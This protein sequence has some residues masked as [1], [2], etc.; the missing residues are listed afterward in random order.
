MQNI[1]SC[2]QYDQVQVTNIQPPLTPSWQLIG[3]HTGHSKGCAD[4]RCRTAALEPQECD[5]RIRLPSS[6]GL[7]SRSYLLGG[8][9]ESAC[10]AACN[11]RPIWFVQRAVNNLSRQ[12][13]QF[14]WL[15][16]CAF[17][18]DPIR[19]LRTRKSK[20]LALDHCCFIVAWDIAALTGNSDDH[21][22]FQSLDLIAVQVQF[23]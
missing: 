13:A 20:D 19:E 7:G 8:S 15:S 10:L 14:P 22:S 5:D 12:S 3:T 17:G 4:V 23:H 9:M 1:Q 21:F 16:E 11:S 2:Q 18:L 6:L